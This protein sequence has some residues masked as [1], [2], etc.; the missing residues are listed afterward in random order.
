MLAQDPVDGERGSIVNIASVEGLA[1]TEG[2]S[3][4]NA[5]RAAS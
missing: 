1:G 4:Y 2:G 5:S 3:T